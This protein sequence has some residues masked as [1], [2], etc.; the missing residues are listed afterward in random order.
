MGQKKTR[1]SRRSDAEEELYELDLEEAADAEL[2]E[3]IQDAVEAVDRD[4]ESR[5]RAEEAPAAAGDGDR[6]ET[7][8]LRERLVRTMAEF[9]NYRKR[10]EREKE[11]LRQIGIFDVVRDFLGVVDNLERALESSG[12]VE[13]LKQ[14]LRMILKQQDEVLRRYGV[15]VIEALGEP[16]DPTLHEAVAREESADVEVPTVTAELQKGYRLRDRLLRPAMVHVA[17]PMQAATAG[18]GGFGEDAGTAVS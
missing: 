6:E 17:M 8:R 9:D 13:D 10:T 3:V 18:R 14:G 2:E 11:S 16:F 1:S 15:E 7:A 4:G 12:N 5:N